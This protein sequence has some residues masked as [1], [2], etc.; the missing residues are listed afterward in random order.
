MRR[1]TAFL[2]PA[3][4]GKTYALIGEVERLCSTNNFESAQCILAITFM[5]GSRR[6]LTSRLHDC[7]KNGVSVHCETIDSFCLRIVNRYRRY[8]GREKPVAIE[9]DHSA[10]SW[11]E[12]Q[13]EWKTSF[14][15]VRKAAVELLRFSVVRSSIGFAYPII[16]VDEFQDC[17][18]EL[19]EIVGLLSEASIVLIAADDFQHLSESA[20]CPAC[21]W[22]HE[23]RGEIRALSGNRR[24]SDSLLHATAAALRDRRTATS[25]IEV[26]APSGPGLVAWRIASKLAP[27]K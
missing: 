26:H 25:S 2:G 15:A 13:R 16:V 17:E 18:N 24:T 7:G 27:G 5:H 8:L 3:G 19:L 12:H 20:S 23:Q 21:C 4:S 22:L 1:I 14:Q 9:H 6:R 10:D 11:I